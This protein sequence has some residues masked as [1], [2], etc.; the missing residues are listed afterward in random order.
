M[1]LHPAPKRD[2]P[3]TGTLTAVGNSEAGAQESLAE[4]LRQPAF[5]E[6]ASLF[7]QFIAAAGNGRGAPGIARVLQQHTGK[8]VVVENPSGQIIA[9]SGAEQWSRA[10]DGSRP[11]RPLP[12]D[13]AHAVAVFDV[14]RWVAVACPRGEVLGA[15]SLLDSG[16]QPTGVDLFELE[17]AATVL[18]WELLHSR[19]LAEV[20]VAL[21]G[22]FATELLEDSDTARVQSHAD[23]L[24]YDL[25]QPHRAVLVLPTAVVSTDLW[26]AVNRAITRLGVKVLSTAR[27][28]GVVMIVAEDLKWAEVAK[29]LRSESESPL[30][31]GVGG[32][33]P[34]RNANRSLSDAEFA[35]SLT[36]S[37][38]DKPVAVFDELGVWRLLA[39]PD[40]GELQILVDH[41]IGPLIDYDREHR[42]ELLKTLIAYLNEF[43]ALEATAAKLYVHRNSLRYRLVRISELTGWDLND[44]EQ[45]FHLDLA[46]RAWQVRQALDG[47]PVAAGPPTN[48]TGVA[49]G[50]RL[51][52]RRSEAVPGAFASKNT[53]TKPRRPGLA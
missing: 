23:R 12:E 50:S 5:Q 33:Y 48:G 39:R 53:K 25:D 29:A 32:L 20:E 27:P 9:A 30:R 2:A 21:W 19:S 44:P 4:L 8:P 15:I 38:I 51:L 52:A 1:T 40:A 11:V 43:G 37:A 41:W 47:T 22:D 31:I 18:G 36:A 28:S 10:S 45:R 6:V 42:S 49:K 3:P 46:C 17:Q 13:A 26:D 14:D 24:G 7:R 35:L 34:L 16:D